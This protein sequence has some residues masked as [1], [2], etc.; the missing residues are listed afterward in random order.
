MLA[1]AVWVESRALDRD[2]QFDLNWI[3]CWVRNWYMK[4]F[5]SDPSFRPV[6]SPIV[7]LNYDQVGPSSN[8]P[9]SVQLNRFVG[10]ILGGVAQFVCTLRRSSPILLKLGR[11]FHPNCPLALC[12]GQKQLVSLVIA[13]SV[14]SS[15]HLPPSPPRPKHHP[16][17]ERYNW[18]KWV[19]SLNVC[20][21]KLPLSL[22]LELE[23]VSLKWCFVFVK[24]FVSFTFCNVVVR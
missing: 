7:I 13:L 19:Y 18:W 4:I 22:D 11:L 5:K 21:L 14:I 12:V 24:K 15:S 20:D 2:F 16:K 10:P 8:C 3:R 6:C 17:R 1:L 23:L 9:E